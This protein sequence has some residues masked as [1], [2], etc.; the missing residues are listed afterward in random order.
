[1]AMSHSDVI[2]IARTLTWGG[3]GKILFQPLATMPVLGELSLFLAEIRRWLNSFR[4]LP[5]TVLEVLSFLNIDPVL[6]PQC[7]IVIVL[8]KLI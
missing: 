1:M 7:D 6:V 5:S 4:S 8:L 2:G 3:K